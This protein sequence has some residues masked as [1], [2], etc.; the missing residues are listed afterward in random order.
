MQKKREEKEKK[1]CY[2]EIC[3]LAKLQTWPND[4]GVRSQR[5]NTS[6]DIDIILL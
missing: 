3:K 4:R 5:V 6:V 2:R 1:E